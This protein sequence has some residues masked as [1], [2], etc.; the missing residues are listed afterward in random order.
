MS[1]GADVHNIPGVIEI[2]QPEEWT[3]N[4]PLLSFDCFLCVLDNL[5]SKTFFC[6][7]Q[8]VTLTSF[9]VLPRIFPDFFVGKRVAKMCFDLLLCCSCTCDPVKLP[10]SYV[11]LDVLGE[12]GYGVVMRCRKRD[13]KEIVAVKISK[14]SDNQEEVG[15]F[16]F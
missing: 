16:F 4:Q 12:G 1:L 14:S 8:G 5:Q 7:F 10:S 15:H 11:L 3:D 9:L 13:T 6:L 2:Y